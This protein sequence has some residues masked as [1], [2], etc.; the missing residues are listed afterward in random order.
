MPPTKATLS[1]LNLLCKR[2]FLPNTRIGNSIRGTAIKTKR[3]NLK[4]VMAINAN[5]PINITN[6]RNVID[7]PV[8]TTDCSKV[9]SLVKREIIS[10][11]LVVSKKLGGNVSK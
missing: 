2:T 3:V 8:P 9:V 4:L 11:V 10:P 5:E 1:W 7:M 6:D